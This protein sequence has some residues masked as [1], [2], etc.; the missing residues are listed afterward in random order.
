MAVLSCIAECH[1]IK[2]ITEPPSGE[3]INLIRLMTQEITRQWYTAFHFY[4]YSNNDPNFSNDPEN[5]NRFFELG[6]KIQPVEW[7]SVAY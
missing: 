1:R 5:R 7:E 2:C 4:F 6:K 3:V